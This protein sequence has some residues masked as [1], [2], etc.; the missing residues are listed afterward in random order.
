MI[1]GGKGY[2]LLRYRKLTP[3][4]GY[5]ISCGQASWECSASLSTNLT[6]RPFESANKCSVQRPSVGKS[7]SVFV[8]FRENILESRFKTSYCWS[9]QQQFE[10][11]LLNAK[12]SKENCVLN[13]QCAV[14]GKYITVRWV[15]RPVAE[16]KRLKPPQGAYRGLIS[17]KRSE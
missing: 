9:R 11:T 14:V 10:T 3:T 7:V 4:V 6:N 5:R 8:I 13:G 1:S 12:K 16:V 2:Q 17:V 15:S